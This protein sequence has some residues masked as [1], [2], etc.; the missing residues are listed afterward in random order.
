ML[1]TLL[2][3]KG[4]KGW[5]WALCCHFHF[6]FMTETRFL[7]AVA[8]NYSWCLPCPYLLT[9]YLIIQVGKK[10]TN[11]A[12]RHP[13]GGPVCNPLGSG[14]ITH[15][16]MLLREQ[17]SPCCLRLPRCAGLLAL[18]FKLHTLPA[19]PCKLTAPLINSGPPRCLHQTYL[20]WR[21]E[22]IPPK[23]EDG[24]WK[25]SA[26]TGK[27]EVPT[28]GS[29]ILGAHTAGRSHDVYFRQTPVRW[30]RE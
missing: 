1:T 2:P 21:S 30:W 5:N 29:P 8:I 3:E 26:R 6:L 7:S 25:T 14:S 9:C 24:K 18:D 28:G 15:Q 22:N 11:Q 10:G 13:P 16:Q 17:V 4:K 19:I 20:F 12:K 27:A 23:Y